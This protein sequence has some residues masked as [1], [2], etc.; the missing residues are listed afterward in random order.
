MN[1]FANV[2]DPRESKAWLFTLSCPSI[3]P[4]HEDF[5]RLQ[6]DASQLIKDTC[7]VLCLS[8]DDPDVVLDTPFSIFDRGLAHPRMWAQYAENHKGVC[9]I[10]EK[11]KL[12]NRIKMELGQ[13]GTIYTG[14][15]V[16]SNLMWPEDNEAFEFDYD[17]IGKAGLAKYVDLHVEKYH[18]NLFFHKARDWS[19]EWEY[20]FILRGSS[21]SYEYVSI[22]DSLVAICIGADFS[23]KSEPFIK[24]ACKKLDIYG[25]RIFWR[26]G[27]PIILPGPYEKG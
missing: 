10:F 15:I 3:S 24:E 12:A 22:E 14:P 8:R 4:S 19:H 6:E 16:Y 2:N 7:K 13:K 17:E 27:H 26:N 1:L 11:E 21:A 18:N 20:R 9:L 23:Q 25:V 5:F